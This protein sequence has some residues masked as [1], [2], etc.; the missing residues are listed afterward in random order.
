[1]RITA[2]ERRPRD[3]HIRVHLD[4]DTHLSFGREVCLTFALR[5]GDQI[6]DTQLA[7]MR[8]AEARRQCLESA[9]RLL[10]Y[11]QRSEAEL[12]DRLVRK[13]VP[14]NIVG[15]TIQRLR[16]A[17]LL[18]DTQFAQRWVDDR[19]QRAPRSRRLIAQE[20]RAKGI[21]KETISG[22]TATVD[23]LDAAYRAA[24]RRARSM[25]SPSHSD[26]RRRIGD[27]LIRRGFDYE[28]VNRTVAR[29]WDERGLPSQDEAAADA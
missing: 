10:S 27:F 9:L 15:D 5:V 8:D 1:M 14:A 16:D 22:A 20:L 23:E 26:F 19:D 17:G 7:A 25:T 3:K 21:N 28:V 13:R 2:L 11:R 12:R 18:D 6:N 4:N 29:L 24:E